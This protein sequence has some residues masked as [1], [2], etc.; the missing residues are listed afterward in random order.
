MA[1]QLWKEMMFSGRFLAEDSIVG[2]FLPNQN[3]TKWIWLLVPLI[4]TL[5][6]FFPLWYIS[7]TP[8]YLIGALVI[9]LVL[10][11]VLFLCLRSPRSLAIKIAVVG[12]LLT[13][14]A[15]GYNSGSNIFF[16]FFVFYLAL[17]FEPRGALLSLLGVVV[18]LLVAAYLFDLFQAYFILPGTIPIVGMSI[19]GVFSR[20]QRKHQD[21]EAKSQLE[22]EQIAVV[23]ERE[24]IARDLHDVLGHTLTSIALKSQ[25]AVK[26]G[27]AGDLDLALTEM[28]QVADICSES[29]S[30]VRT[31]ISGYKAK[32][33]ASQ[34]LNLSE[35]LR[36]QGLAVEQNCNF[37]KL[38]AKSEAALSLIL[39]EV[40]TNILRHS[41]ATKVSLHTENSAHS[42]TL[43]IYDNGDVPSV[44]K[45][46]NGLQGIR[47]RLEEI[48]GRLEIKLDSGMH[49][50][51]TV[52]Y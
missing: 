1:L 27:R 31:A 8:L 18:C 28:Q 36:A 34:V 38:G 17:C 51:I 24:R 10:L 46:G 43:V 23:A 40:V 22:L 20:L 29:L 30:E 26:L 45:E 15:C 2:E 12:V 48:N 47:E 13:A 44:I 4:Y 35:R 16:C 9:Y 42:C 33:I 41:N 25:L 21:R 11:G 14:L 50:I 7:L 49:I 39:T 5:F 3:G 37:E 52:D 32:T 6:Y 19:F